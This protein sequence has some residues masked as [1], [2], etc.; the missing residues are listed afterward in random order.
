MVCSK[1]EKKLGTLITPDTWKEGSRNARTGSQGRALGKNMLATKLGETGTA[2]KKDKGDTMRIEDSNKSSEIID[3][4]AHA[5][6]S[7]V[8]DERGNTYWYNRE[9]GQ[10][11]WEKPNEASSSSSSLG[12]ENE[13]TKTQDKDGKTYYYNSRTGISQWEAPA[14]GL[15]KGWETATHTDGKS[16]EGK[17]KGFY[18]RLGEEGLGYYPDERPK[19]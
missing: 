19:N 13:W 17:K 2:A 10:T 11:Q 15:S 9:T 3:K 5:L 16:F 12:S 8:T 1:C 7:K 18:F 4:S 14:A 6:W